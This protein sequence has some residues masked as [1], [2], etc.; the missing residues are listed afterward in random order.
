MYDPTDNKTD[1]LEN[2]DISSDVGDFVAEQIKMR[3]PISPEDSSVYSD[4]G[5]ILSEEA[6]TMPRRYY[7]APEKEPKPEKQPTPDCPKG[8][9]RKVMAGILVGA[10]M[11]AAIGVGVMGAVEDKSSPS[12]IEEVV[13]TAEPEQSP[14]LSIA[15]S[16]SSDSISATDIYNLAT[17]QVVGINTEITTT[18]IFGQTTT[19][20]VSGSGFIVTE[21]GYILTNYHVIEDAY[22]QNLDV[23]VILYNGDSYTASIVGFEDY[24][25]DIAVL[26]IDA[27]G[28]TPVTLGDSSE[29]QVGEDIYAVGN[30]LGE[31]AY[32]MT[33]GMI[34]AL[35]RDITS[36]EQYTGI[37]TTVNMFQISAAVNSGN[38][39]GPVYNDSGE[40]VGIVTAKYSSSGVEGL[41]FAIPINDAA[42]IANDLIERGYVSGKPSMGVT[43]QTMADNV[44]A[45]YGVPV[46]AY[47][48][49]IE[50]NSCAKSAG[51]EVGDIITAIDDYEIGGNSDLKASLKH[52]GAGDTA[53]LTVY[54]DNDY[55]TLSIT[56]DEAVPDTEVVG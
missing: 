9:F 23:N 34:S 2:P 25:S 39:G 6:P 14:V 16:D 36:E 44:A 48:F 42:D 12:A 43:V 26:K 53:T 5:Y 18:N 41:G 8:V 37:V 20:A 56:F 10:L 11:G 32:T 35:D 40:V 38:S 15:N 31:L 50:E 28:L 1:E 24:D 47:V 22:E 30:P 52:Y 13:Q 55:V 21:D 3:E 7:T 19:N 54:R 33:D 46:G 4:A 17:A 49:L 51:L 27:E 29:I 45:Y